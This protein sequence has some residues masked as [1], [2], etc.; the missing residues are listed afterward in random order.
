MKDGKLDAFFWSGG[1]P[2][3]AVLDLA[4]ARG[5]RV[6]LLPNS[7]VLP[8]LQRRYGATLYSARTI[9]RS[10]YPGLEVD[11]PVVAVANL[12]VVHEKMPEELAYHITRLL[13]DK[14]PVLAAIHPEARN[15]ALE[16]AVTGSPAPFHKGAIRYYRDRHAW[17][18]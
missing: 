14:Q 12:L 2:T 13:F 1:L 15:L 10:A 7:D 9:S 5:L 18:N 17:K 4:N 8:A 16:S 3:A 6:T 11:V